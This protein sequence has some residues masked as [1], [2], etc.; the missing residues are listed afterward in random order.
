MS[1]RPY[2]GERLAVATR[3]GKARALRVPF[4]RHLGAR[5]HAPP[6]LDTDALGSFSGEVP[7]RHDALDTARRKA[8]LL[9]PDLHPRVIASEGSFGPDPLVGFTA[10]QW[11]LL[12]FVD[13]RIGF[14]VAEVLAQ[15]ACHY[16][17][18]EAGDLEQAWRFLDSMDFP[19]HGAVVRP[20]SAHTP[21]AK[22]IHDTHRFARAYARARD[23][24]PDGI[25]HV[26][27]DVR[28]HHH[29]W[30]MSVIA[31]A[32]A[33]LAHRLQRHCPAC[34]CPGWGRVGSRS[35][36]PCELCRTPTGALATIV[37]GCPR[38]RTTR[39]IDVR[40]EHADPMHC[41]CCNP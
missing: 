8:A 13:R 2:A 9:D 3:H 30:R 38:C 27:M 11:E 6:A 12:L 41:P 35:G 40:R 29:P 10:M 28:A 39:E 24:D 21:L 4:A 16:G 34:G 20:R 36:L 32:A 14:E 15:P 23:A 7:R 31:R 22:G 5:V 19:R 26:E 18:V 1:L 17:H 33:R 37:E 25:V